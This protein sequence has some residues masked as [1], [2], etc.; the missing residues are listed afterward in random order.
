MSRGGTWTR[1]SG[2]TVC[3][4]NAAT[5]STAGSKVP[6]RRVAIH[7]RRVNGI[8]F[9]GLAMSLARLLAIAA[10]VVAGRSDG[11]PWL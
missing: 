6:P 7:R 3:R 5:R 9:R 4:A 11:E 10:V 1:T 2:G 8:C